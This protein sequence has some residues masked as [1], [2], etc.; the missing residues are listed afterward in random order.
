[1]SPGS[2]RQLYGDL[3]GVV[4]GDVHRRSL[5]LHPVPHRCHDE[6][7]PRDTPR[8]AHDGAEGDRLAGRDSLRGRH[9]PDRF[10]TRREQHVRSTPDQHV[11]DGHQTE[12]HQHPPQ[13]APF[14]RSPATAIDELSRDLGEGATALRGGRYGGGTP[15]PSPVPARLPCGAGAPRSILWRHRRH[16]G[17]A[18]RP[19]D[20]PLRSESA[21]AVPSRTPDVTTALR[22]RS[23]PSSRAG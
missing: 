3:R 7:G 23:H 11:D 10:H 6:G 14:H 12:G 22:P 16:T 4:G 15:L 13:D 8:V 9:R 17:W 5:H 18:I 20:P 19:R 1:M 2:Q 21:R